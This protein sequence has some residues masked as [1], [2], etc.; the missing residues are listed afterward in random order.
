M[1]LPIQSFE[2]GM[3]EDYS[4]T[5]S[6]DGS[7]KVPVET[8]SLDDHEQAIPHRSPRLPPHRLKQRHV[9]M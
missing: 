7:S 4:T 3:A 5:P 6:A 1:H 9:Q 8:F 2:L